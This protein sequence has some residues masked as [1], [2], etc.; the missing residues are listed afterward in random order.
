MKKIKIEEEAIEAVVL[1]LKSIGWNPLVGGFIGIEQG[2]AKFN[3]R[4]IFGF[5][6][7]KR[8]DKKRMI[9]SGTGDFYQALPE[10]KKE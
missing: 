5:T 8:K 9:E 6:G 3:F 1:Y 4:L 7:S 10:G 2:S